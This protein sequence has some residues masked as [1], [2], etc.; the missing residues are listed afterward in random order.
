MS[1]ARRDN[2][3]DAAIYG[4]LLLRLAIDGKDGVNC[5]EGK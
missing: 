1:V 2:S 3:P 4:L 5:E